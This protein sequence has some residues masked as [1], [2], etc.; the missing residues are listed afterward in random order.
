[1]NSCAARPR[2]VCLNSQ[3]WHTCISELGLTQF[4]PQRAA[5][6]AHLEMLMLRP[7][8]PKEVPVVYSLARAPV[9]S[10]PLLVAWCKLY[11]VRPQERARDVARHAIGLVEGNERDDD[12]AHDDVVDVAAVPVS[13]PLH[14]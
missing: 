5:L 9:D 7:A 4:S 6:L 11:Q 10:T 3:C 13:A 2:P 8:T 12:V 14:A 1:M